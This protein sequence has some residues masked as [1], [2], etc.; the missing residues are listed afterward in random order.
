M[1]D[2]IKSIKVENDKGKTEC[3]VT[4]KHR[5]QNVTII[6]KDY[7]TMIK[8]SLT[9]A[10]KIKITMDNLTIMFRTRARKSQLLAKLLDRI[11][12][13]LEAD[14]EKNYALSVN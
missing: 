2:K 13:W 3:K 1:Q 4:V 7:L 10:D 12:I 6:S 14:T 5:S 8:I 9:E 11:Q